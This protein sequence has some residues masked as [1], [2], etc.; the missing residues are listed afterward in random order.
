M[1]KIKLWSASLY[2][3]PHCYDEIYVYAKSEE[4][5]RDLVGLVYIMLLN[6]KDK[7]KHYKNAKKITLRIQT[8]D[9]E[10]FHGALE[11]KIIY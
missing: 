5:L 4:S 11:H 6:H 2:L 7:C 10:D 1:S 3:C 8:L 9:D